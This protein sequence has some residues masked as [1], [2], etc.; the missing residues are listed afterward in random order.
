MEATLDYVPIP[1]IDIAVPVVKEVDNPIIPK[2]KRTN[3]FIRFREKTLEEEKRQ[4]EYDL[5][6][7][8]DEW[9]SSVVNR[10]RSLLSE[11]DFEAVI[12]RFEKRTGFSRELP[13]FSEMP[14]IPN[15]S[16]ELLRKIYDYWRAKR[17]ARTSKKTRKL[18]PCGKPLLVQFEVPP[19]FDNNDPL[20]PFRPREK[21]RY[22][23]KVLFLF[24]LFFFW[25]E[26]ERI[27][28]FCFVCR[29]T[30]KNHSKN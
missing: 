26:I 23:R 7:S 4:I 19:P 28:F 9:L 20:V 25:F 18:Y 3:I 22:S 17:L 29:R 10:E 13:D 27:F 2:F 14:A 15:I 11:N 8:D 5:D 30:I 1:E 24:V 21:D 16:N 6:S 12:D